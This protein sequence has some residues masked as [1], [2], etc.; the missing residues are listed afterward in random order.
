VIPQPE[1]E[2]RRRQKERA[3]VTAILL[4][5]FVVLMFAISIAK[6]VVQP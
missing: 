6:M 2:I 1:D 4:G 3:R 5:L